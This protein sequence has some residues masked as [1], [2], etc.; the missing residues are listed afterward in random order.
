[1]CASNMDGNQNS[2]VMYLSMFLIDVITMTIFIR[3]K[4]KNRAVL[5]SPFVDS[6]KIIL[7]P[8]NTKLYHQF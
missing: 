5:L 3:K 8:A 7:P 1:M 6:N 4:K 2:L